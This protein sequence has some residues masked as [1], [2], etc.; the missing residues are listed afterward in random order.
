MSAHVIRAPLTAENADRARVVEDRSG[1]VFRRMLP[2]HTHW[3]DDAMAQF[4][5]EEMVRDA[6]KFGTVVIGWF[7]LPEA[8]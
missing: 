4:S 2:Q 6:A 3:H 8:S 5:H 1:R 7:R